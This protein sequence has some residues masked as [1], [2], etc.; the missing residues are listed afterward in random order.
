MSILR[1][2]SSAEQVAQYLRGQLMERVWTGMMPGGNKL[3][4][5]LGV[6]A[7]TIEAA[8]KILENEGLLVNQ[9]RR[10]GRRIE[11]PKKLTKPSMRVGILIY[12]PADR[13]VHWIGDL[14]HRLDTLG[15]TSFIDDKKSLTELGMDVKKIALYAQKTETDAWVIIAG[16]S[17]ILQWFADQPLPAFALF[18]RHRRVPLASI[19]ADKI[20]A[21]SAILKRLIDLGH[22]RI[23]MLANEERRKP[24]L[25]LTELAFLDELK[26]HGIESGPYNLPDW[27]GNQEGFYKCLDSLF[28]HTPPTALIFSQVPHF[29][30]AQQYLAHRG[31]LIPEHISLIS[32]DPDPVF[33]WCRPSIAHI[34]FDILPLVRRVV[35]WVDKVSRGIEDQSKSLIPAEFIEGGTVGPVSKER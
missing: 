5:E 9:G 26:A 27:E 12:E 17:E 13:H 1:L 18:G 25:G 3:A 21:Q 11:I 28:E 7:N 32:R 15:H 16:S 23:V 29:I 31:V 20:T 30:A 22:R 8:L 2:L 6:G 10:H 34:S 4:R 14:Q 35:Q 19:G 24:E 33:E